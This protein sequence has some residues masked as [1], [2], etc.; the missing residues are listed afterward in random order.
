MSKEIF[1]RTFAIF[2]IMLFVLLP[3]Y[4][5]DAMAADIL[6]I[7][8]HGKD[9][10]PGIRA[11][12]DTMTV[13]VE[14]SAPGEA[15]LTNKVK[16][17]EDMRALT[18]TGGGNATPGMFHC[19]YQYPEGTTL[20]DMWR[21]TVQIFNDA[22]NPISSPR[23][24]SLLVD[25][26]AP[27]VNA[28]NFQLTTDDS[29]NIIAM[30]TV[31][32]TSCYTS[33]C[34]GKCSG[35]KK[36]E[37]KSGLTVVGTYSNST[38][39]CTLSGSTIIGITPS[40]T[41]EYS[42]CMVATDNVGQTSD[43]AC[44]S[45]TLDKTTPTLDGGVVI[46]DIDGDVITATKGEP[47]QIRSVRFN[48]T[49][50]VGIDAAFVDLIGFDPR[51]G[52]EGH[53][54]GI[55]ASCS[56]PS[57]GKFS[58]SASPAGAYLAITSNAELSVRIYVRD[59]SGNILNTSVA[60]PVIF[61]QTPPVLQGI[62]SDYVDDVGMY[63]LNESGF[64]IKAMFDE[65]GSGMGQ[66]KVLM[67]VSALGPQTVTAGST[68]ATVLRPNDCVET[69]NVWECSW[70]NLQANSASTGTRVTLQVTRAEDDAGNVMNTTG[71][72]IFTVDKSAP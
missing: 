64:S 48:V 69:A 35:I 10:V 16:I 6:S 21:F 30:F 49:E 47:I 52:Y 71:Y 53:Y 54:T 19:Q 13:E 28:G 42:I 65:A 58:C 41:Q 8:A 67:D 7:N 26:I 60:Y 59:S 22:N 63:W 66:K 3:V 4:V 1:K 15:S 62:A 56:G 44:K 12:T 27:T 46:T 40:G 23:A 18:C 5:S 38:S 33:N 25:S 2:A 39:A 29:G 55:T 34:M 36:V 11:G 50:D 61:D 32:D 24:A 9:N 43:P 51:P 37:F 17:L 68:S 70:D 45:I 14:A 72:G 20:S 31:E 57:N